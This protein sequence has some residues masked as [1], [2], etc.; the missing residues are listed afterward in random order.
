MAG[1]LKCCRFC[2]R[3]TRTNH[4]VCFRCEGRKSFRNPPSHAAALDKYAPPSEC[5]MCGKF[6]RSEH[7]LCDECW[8]VDAEHSYHGDN[9]G[10]DDLG[11]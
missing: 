9:Y 3:D 1:E 4:G 2:G 8:G 10:E 11:R 6:H 5:V 7:R